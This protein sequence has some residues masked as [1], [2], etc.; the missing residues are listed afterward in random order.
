M[1]SF[2]GTSYHQ[3]IAH[4]TAGVPGTPLHTHLGS[5]QVADGGVARGSLTPAGMLQAVSLPDLVHY[6]SLAAGQGAWKQELGRQAARHVTGEVGSATVARNANG[7]GN[8]NAVLHAAHNTTQLTSTG[9]SSPPPAA[10]FPGDA[11][12]QHVAQTQQWQ[13]VCL[14]SEA[15]WLRP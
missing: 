9:P 8:P 1:P 14:I 15:P 5:A 11:C 6:R 3:R 12:T 4:S 2:L 10:F 13:G 7:T